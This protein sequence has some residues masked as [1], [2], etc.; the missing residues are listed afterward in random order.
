MSA[1]LSGGAPA[2]L[3]LGTG[4]RQAAVLSGWQCLT[5]L[6]P[7]Q[8]ITPHFA[9]LPLPPCNRGNEGQVVPITVSMER[10]ALVAIRRGCWGGEGEMGGEMGESSTPASS[11]AAASPI[12]V[13]GAEG[14]LSSEATE[15]TA[16]V[17]QSLRFPCHIHDRSSSGQPAARALRPC[18]AAWL[19]CQPWPWQ[20]FSWHLQSLARAQTLFCEAVWSRRVVRRGPRG[21]NVLLYSRTAP[22]ALPVAESL[23]LNPYGLMACAD[24]GL[25]PC[26]CR[27]PTPC[28][29]P[30]TTRLPCRMCIRTA[31]C[32]A[33]CPPSHAGLTH[34]PAT[35]LLICRISIDDGVTNSA[36]SV[37][38]AVVGAGPTNPNG[39]KPPITW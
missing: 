31:A 8:Q 15:P 23:V 3:L 12:R 26:A 37:A 38:D 14:E 33:N 4:C 17:F 7:L 30:P 5:P 39:C 36:L 2:L 1:Q 35:H 29:A 18:P 32:T 27:P 34:Y 6:P 16:C 24:R 20:R 28:P 11:A 19:G 22:K 13:G 10:A 21:G 9:C 25:P